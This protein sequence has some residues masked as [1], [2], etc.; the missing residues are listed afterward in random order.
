MKLL[1]PQLISVRLE[2]SS[3]IQ[4]PCDCCKILLLQHTVKFR[5][6]SPPQLF[7]WPL[8][9]LLVPF[10]ALELRSVFNVLE[11][12]EEYEAEFGVKNT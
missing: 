5:Y 9:H 3:H 12:N 7:S 1:D 2:R 8:R 10:V 6:E 11:V 4:W